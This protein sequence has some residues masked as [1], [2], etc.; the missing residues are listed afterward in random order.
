MKGT[1]MSEQPSELIEPP[2]DWCCQD[3]DEAGLGDDEG[4]P[5]DGE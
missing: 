2:Q 1:A 5:T 4:G 3:S